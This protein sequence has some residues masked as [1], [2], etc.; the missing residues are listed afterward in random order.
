MKLKSNVLG[1]TI[2][3]VIFGGI[4]VTSSLNM[5]STTSSKIPETYKTG[6]FAGKYDPA[7]IRGSYTFEDIKHSFNIPVD[8]LAKAFGVEDSEDVKSFQVKNLE[9]LYEDLA[10][11][12]KEIG[13]GS[14]RL[15]VGLYLGL[16]V[17]LDENVFLLKPAVDIL[18][19]QKTLKNDQIE[20][21]K[22]QMVDLGN[23]N[24]KIE[25]TEEK[26]S[27]DEHEEE[28]AVKGKTT[29]DEAMNW[30]L[31][32][33]VIE[34]TIGGEIPARGMT[35]RDY[36]SQNGIEFSSVKEKLNELL[37]NK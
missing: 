17:E 7:D 21:I 9:S 16:P 1:I 35:I 29:F 4:L 20:F 8:V 11:E 5:W 12:G 6:E 25:K 19:E 15:F 13:S 23:I 36:C 18:L 24:N 31:S 32:K 37:E 34:E 2:L 26:V 30:G 14:V 3:L 27:V 22:R 33:E 28:M 10:N